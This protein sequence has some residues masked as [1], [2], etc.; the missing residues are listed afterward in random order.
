MNLEV[1]STKK[2]E[3]F[4][5]LPH[6]RKVNEVQVANLVASIGKINLTQ[7]NP[8]MVKDLKVIDGQH[9]LKA[10]EILGVDVYYV[11]LDT[12][13][14]SEIINAIKLL[15]NNS[16]NWSAEDFLNLYCELGFEDYIKVK[17]FM[18]DDLD[19]DNPEKILSL[20]VAIFFLS[21]FSQYKNAVNKSF[22]E[23][24][25]KIKKENEIKAK[26][27]LKW[28]KTTKRIVSSFYDRKVDTRFLNSSSFTQAFGDLCDQ[29]KFNHQ[30]FLSNLTLIAEESL[31]APIKSTDS[32]SGYYTQ[33]A[34]IHNYGL[35]T[36]L[37]VDE[38]YE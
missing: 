35:T 26:N 33:L 1:K 10:C 21:G 18:F 19:S 12:L 11:E 30:V 34:Q 7:F 24:T 23:G 13:K 14:E 4:K 3:M 25:F 29:G 15:N 28:Y 9:R 38:F 6:N 31:E 36:G 2:Y 16:K 32:K 27:A 17:N 5:T 22:K 8:I 37:K 20:S